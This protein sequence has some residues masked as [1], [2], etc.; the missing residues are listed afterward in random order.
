MAAKKIEALER[1]CNE[2]KGWIE[3]EE[4]IIAKIL[5]RQQDLSDQVDRWNDYLI[6]QQ[7]APRYRQQL[8]DSSAELSRPFGAGNEPNPFGARG[9]HD[10][11]DNRGSAIAR[12]R[13]GGT[14]KKIRK[15]RRKTRKN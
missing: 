1:C 6:D 9:K 3:N 10:R 13:R 8:L 7:E 2:F 11:A 4:K 5:E 12:Q 15:R 14:R